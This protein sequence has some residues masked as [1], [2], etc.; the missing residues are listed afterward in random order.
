MKKCK[1]Q[2]GYTVEAGHVPY[3]RV[4]GRVIRV[5]E[6]P[7]VWLAWTTTI[8]N[9][10]CYAPCMESHSNQMWAMS[11]PPLKLTLSQHQY[12][13]EWALIRLSPL[14]GGFLPL[15]CLAWHVDRLVAQYV[16]WLSC[17][18]EQPVPRLVCLCWRQH[19]LHGRWSLQQHLAAS[20]APH[21]IQTVQ[22]WMPGTRRPK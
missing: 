13:R 7:E 9:V 2:L 18:H 1:K 6:P 19:G 8:P 20:I 12:K 10:A 16:P 14:A 4:S 3:Q 21:L 5:R 17:C 15:E 11:M 22:G